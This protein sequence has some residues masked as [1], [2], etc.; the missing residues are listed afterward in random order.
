MRRLQVRAIVYILA[1]MLPA[2]V[3]SVLVPAYRDWVAGGTGILFVAVTAFLIGYYR[4][5]YPLTGPSLAPW[6]V[7]AMLL[8]ALSPIV[9]AIV[10]FVW[11]GS[12]T[13]ALTVV[14]AVFAAGLLFVVAPLMLGRKL[15]R[16]RSARI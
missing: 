12:A 10:Q 15:G 13:Y 9:V 4:N 16:H 14:A 7:S 2:I 1:F 11:S 5:S 3:V 8:I 6:Q